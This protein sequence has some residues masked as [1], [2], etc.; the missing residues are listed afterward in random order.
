MRRL[1][2][3]VVTC[4]GL[5]ALV[6][7]PAEAATPPL[8]QQYAPLNAQIVKIGVDIAS[9]VNG[10]D[11]ETDAQLAKQF[12]G[13]A[14]RASAASIK[15]GKLKGATGA[16]LTFQ[17]NLQLALVKGASDL[18]AIYAAAVT[19]SASRAKTATIKLYK[20]SVPIKSFRVSLAKSLGIRTP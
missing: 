19:H 2:L 1:E 10:A 6:S 18:A 17:R 16:N 15:V 12:Q 7:A 20:D 14:I 4:V 8:K 13:L 11:K 5:L 9:A 3:A